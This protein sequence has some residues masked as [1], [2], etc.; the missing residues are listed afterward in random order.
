MIKSFKFQF[1]FYRNSK[2]F[3]LG[4]QIEAFGIAN[5]VV[6]MLHN[7]VDGI[8]MGLSWGLSW[9]A[10][11]SSAIAVAVHE[12]PQEL[13]DFMVLRCAG[14]GTTQLLFWNF[15]ASLSCFAGV[16][17]VCYVGESTSQAVQNVCFA[18][19]GGSFLSLNKNIK[20]GFEILIFHF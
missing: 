17:L 9:S 10:G 8:T 7:F 6:E 15:I 13:G 19:T 12:L 11:L 3:V 14:F 2:N 5:L 4:Q 16:L 20:N 18:L 1:F